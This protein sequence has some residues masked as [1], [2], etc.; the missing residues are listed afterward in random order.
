VFSLQ[1]RSEHKP[2]LTP[3]AYQTQNSLYLSGGVTMSR[4]NGHA[5][6][7]WMAANA[8]M[9]AAIVAEIPPGRRG[10]RKLK[11]VPPENL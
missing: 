4:R 9:A 2:C 1:R 11:T 7:Q 5:T 8:A 10:Y 6:N 3:F